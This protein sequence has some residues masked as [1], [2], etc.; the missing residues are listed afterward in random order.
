MAEFDF[1]VA[2]R[3][4]QK[5]QFRT[6]RRFVPSHLFEAEN[7]F[8]KIHSARKVVHAVTGVQKFFDFGHVKK[9]AAPFVAAIALSAFFDVRNFRL[10]EN[11]VRRALDEME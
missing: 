2:L 5:N 1:L 3:C 9:I 11:R 6:A 7:V 4:F 10:F 8:V